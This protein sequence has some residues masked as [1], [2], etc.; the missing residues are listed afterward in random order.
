MENVIGHI[1]TDR[2]RRIVEYTPLCFWVFLENWPDVI[3]G[4]ELQKLN[5]LKYYEAVRGPT[6]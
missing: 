1:L 4:S 3:C 2:G 6:Q 5:P